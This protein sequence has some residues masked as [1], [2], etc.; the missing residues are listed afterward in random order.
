MRTDLRKAILSIMLLVLTIPLLGQNQSNSPYSR[1]GIGDLTES[2]FI[3]LRSMGGLSASY[4]DRFHLNVVNPASYAFLSSTAFH[5]GLNASLSKLNDGVRNSSSWNGSL[6]Y[7]SLGFPLRN[8]INEV[9]DRV[10]KP[11]SLGMSFSLLSNSNVDYNISSFEFAEDIGEIERNYSGSGGTTKFLWGNAI[12]YNDFSFG[13]HLGYLFGKINYERNIF[14]RDIQQARDDNFLSDFNVSSL[15]FNMGFMYE[16][17]LNEDEIEQNQQTPAK[18]VSFGL[19][20]T[21]KK[22][23]ST[24]SSE[25]KRTIYRITEFTELEDTL[26]IQTGIEGKG[27]M[28]SEFG[29]GAM[30]YYDSK[31]ALG[32][33]YKLTKWSQYF[34]DANPGT[35]QDSYKVSF[36]GFYRPEYRGFVSFYQRIFY[37][38]GIY[39]GNDARAIEDESLK[40]YGLNLGFGLPITFQRKISH[41]NLGFDLGRRS[42]SSSIKETYFK[43][44][45]DLTF[46]DSE[47]FIKRKL[48]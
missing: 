28:P 5:V 18:R 20:F 34:N 24:E 25:I 19:H 45:L 33:N 36:G 41:V 37:R 30:Y 43:I 23:F 47:W 21:P 44:G 8:P 42:S 35:L 1:F 11:Y 22:G 26:S 27:S 7:L 12:K 10:N 40:N 29:I 46:N 2:E 13:I 39:Y 6:D 16:K 48:D 15:L 9:Y 31:L 4:I 3:N 17:T 14:F 32:V 38:F